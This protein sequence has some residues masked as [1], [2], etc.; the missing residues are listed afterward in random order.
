MIILEGAQTSTILSLCPFIT[1]WYWNFSTVEQFWCIA[2]LLQFFFLAAV[3]HSIFEDGHDTT[4][5]ALSTASGQY[6][7][8]IAYCKGLRT[9]LF[10]VIVCNFRLMLST[11]HSL[12]GIAAKCEPKQCRR[13]SHVL[14]SELE[15]KID[16][17]FKTELSF[18]L[19]KTS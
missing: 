9:S 7:A 18:A 1:Q 17:F 19:K 15:K 5:S 11:T 16:L 10:I 13:H 2:I 8:P 4:Y 3:S 12:P 14:F 6:V